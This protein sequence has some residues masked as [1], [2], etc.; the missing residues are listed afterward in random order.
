[1]K[2]HIVY[3]VY[4]GTFKLGKKEGKGFLYK[5]HGTFQ[6]ELIQILTQEWE[7]GKQLLAK[8]VYIKKESCEI[9]KIKVK[10]QGSSQI[11]I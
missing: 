11:S 3:M 2:K 10:N 5:F 6:P 8:T 7:T 4:N 9:C 1:M